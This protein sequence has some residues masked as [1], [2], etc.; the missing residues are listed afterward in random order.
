MSEGG[1]RPFSPRFHTGAESIAVVSDSFNVSLGSTNSDAETTL[2]KHLFNLVPEQ[3]VPGVQ[4][5]S[6]FFVAAHGL[7]IRQ[8]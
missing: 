5:I 8:L 1:P 6:G 7:R 4:R 3:L 2:A